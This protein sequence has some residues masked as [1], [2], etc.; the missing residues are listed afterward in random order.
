MQRKFTSRIMFVLYLVKTNNASE[1]TLRRLPLPVHLVTKPEFRNFFKGNLKFW[2]FKTRCSTT[3]VAAVTRSTGQNCTRDDELNNEH[4]KCSLTT[5]YLQDNSS[6][7]NTA[8][9]HRSPSVPDSQHKHS[10]KT[11]GGEAHW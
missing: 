2:H 6:T 9:S 3:L 1:C 7:N 11:E 5:F 10:Q 4:S 8:N